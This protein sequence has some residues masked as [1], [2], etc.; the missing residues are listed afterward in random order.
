MIVAAEETT[1][2]WTA[3]RG[4]ASEVF[5]WGPDP[6]VRVLGPDVLNVRPTSVCSGDTAYGMPSTPALTDLLV[7]TF[8]TDSNDSRDMG[9]SRFPSHSCGLLFSYDCHGRRSGDD[10]GTSNTI[11]DFTPSDKWLWV[12]ISP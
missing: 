12:E 5:S 1:A 6:V 11:C 8:Y 10:I 3:G 7:H 2:D 4:A 9:T